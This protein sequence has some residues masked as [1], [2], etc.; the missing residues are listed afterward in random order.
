MRMHA[1]E[2]R[3]RFIASIE[4]NPWMPLLFVSLFVATV[5]WLQF[6][7]SPRWSLW[8]TFALLALPMLG[9]VWVC[10]R[11]GTSSLVFTK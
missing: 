7:P 11:I 2:A 9:Y 1:A 3:L 6:R 10:M 8:I 5:L 4:A